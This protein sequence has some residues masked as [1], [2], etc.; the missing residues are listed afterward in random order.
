MEVYIS[1]GRRK[2]AV[3]R[4]RMMPGSGKIVINGTE[5][6]LAYFKRETL[7]MDIEQPLVLTENLDKFDFQINVQGGG[8]SGQAG[9]VRLGIA[10]ALLAYSEDYRKVLRQGGFL[11]RDPREKERKKYGLAKARKRFQFSKR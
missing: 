3:A 5:G 4:V 6:L 10:R 9:A 11:T 7:K 1:I 2:G 8:L